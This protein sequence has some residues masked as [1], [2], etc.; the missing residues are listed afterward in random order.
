MFWIRTQSYYPPN[1]RERN[2]PQMALGSAFFGATFVKVRGLF[3]SLR[4]NTN[5]ESFVVTQEETVFVS[6]RPSSQGGL[7]NIL[8]HVPREGI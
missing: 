2:C 8:I 4:G 1:V 3:L 5:W 6:M 7:K